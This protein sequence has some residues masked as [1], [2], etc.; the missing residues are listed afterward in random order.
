[1]PINSTPVLQNI[2]FF[3][4]KKKNYQIYKR[5][6]RSNQNISTR[7]GDIISSIEKIHIFY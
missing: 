3:N 6:K 2:V 1:M 5:E 4:L 7:F